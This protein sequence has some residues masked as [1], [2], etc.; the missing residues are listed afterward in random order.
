M[1]ILRIFLF[2]LFI[3]T[4]NAVVNGQGVFDGNLKPFYHGVASGDPLS[5]AVIIWTRYTP[6]STFT[7]GN[8][9]VNWRV[10]SDTAMNQIVSFGN[11]TTSQSRDYTV[12]VDV[13]GLQPNTFYY[14]DFE[15][16]G[17]YSMK[18]RTKTAPMGDSDSLRFAVLSCANF[19]RGYFNTYDAV[20]KRNDIDAVIHLGDYIYEY[21][22]GPNLNPNTPE[23]TF[24]PNYEIVKIEDYRNRYSSYRLDEDLRN[25]HQQYPFINVWDDHEIVNNS[26]KTGA[27]NHDS[28]TEGPWE[29]RKAIAAKVFDEWLPI[30][31]PDTTNLVKIWRTL[32]YGNLAKFHLLDTRIWGR[33]KHDGYNN[34]DTNRTILGHDQLQ[35][36][37]DELSASSAQWNIVAQQ[38]MFAPLTVDSFSISDDKWD[39]YPAE[40]EK[41]INHILNNSIN[42]V[43][44]ITGDIHSTW[45]GDI[46]SANYDTL[47]SQGSAGVEFVTPSVTT[48]K[49][50]GIPDDFLISL[51]KHMKYVNTK[52]RGYMDLDVNKQR[53]Q[54]DW[55]FI[56]TIDSKTYTSFFATAYL[57]HYGTRHLDTVPKQPSVPRSQ[58]K[59]VL[60]APKVPL[61]IV[62]LQNNVE[63]LDVSIFPNPSENYV[64][65][66]FYLPKPTEVNVKFF[67]INGREIYTCKSYSHA[68]G[69]HSKIISLEE[70]SKGVYLYSIET[71]TGFSKK[72]KL[73]LR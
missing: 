58:L 16:N 13:V 18:G 67:D 28:I 14:Y 35:W 55:Y 19:E 47:T 40:R 33:D 10:A 11:F 72:G 70:F 59:N 22:S 44:V 65:L 69:Y 53:T 63:I 71:A 62:D 42:D 5:N 27:Q 12:K 32:D 23:R 56:S 2:L 66:R 20:T 25:L 50:M 41:I 43:V 52:N 68:I 61:S 21:G 4:G 3:V 36:F 24:Y 7:G 39:G 48:V 6:D 8:V 17:N 46:P 54:A 26:Y 49:P 60:Q 31:L 45:V 64:S 34:Y 37:K 57:T 51:Y 38:V 73:V 9:V 30:R 15:V 29:T 1:F